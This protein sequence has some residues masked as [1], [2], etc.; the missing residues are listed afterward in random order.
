ML[1]LWREGLLAKAVLEGRT[2]AY[3]NHP[4]LERFKNH[5]MPQAAI[6]AYLW[7]VAEEAER[8]GYRFD[9]AKLGPRQSCAPIL[10]TD[11]QLAYE[12]EHLQQK[13]QLRDPARFRQNEMTSEILPHPLMQ[14]VPGGVA[15]WERWKE[16]NRP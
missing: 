3:R 4:Q 7:A 5:P 11:G 1:A 13:L 2:T 9:R 10:V 16:D 8:R 14:I 15:D 6:D 12:W